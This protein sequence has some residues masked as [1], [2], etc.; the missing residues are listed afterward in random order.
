MVVPHLAMGLGKQVH[1]RLQEAIIWTA[2][3]VSVTSLYFLFVSPPRAGS[4]TP[5]RV[6]SADLMAITS[7]AA[8]VHQLPGDGGRHLR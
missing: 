7:S 5:Q 6:R 2:A 8:E 1:A 4:V 3:G